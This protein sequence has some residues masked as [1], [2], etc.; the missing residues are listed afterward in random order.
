MSIICSLLNIYIF[1]VFGRII[2]EW[3]QVPSDHPVG[4][5]RRGLATVVD[6]VLRPLRRVIPPVRIG[7]GALDFSPLI[8]I[9]GIVILQQVIC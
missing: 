1:V 3:I 4:A 2:L 5:V 8:L 6:P 7:M 9:I